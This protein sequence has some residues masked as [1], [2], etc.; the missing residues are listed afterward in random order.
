MALDAQDDD[1]LEPPT[2]EIPMQLHALLLPPRS[3]RKLQL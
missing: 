2:G 1:P 3:S